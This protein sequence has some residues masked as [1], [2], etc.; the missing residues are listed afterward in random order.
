ME[1]TVKLALIGKEMTLSFGVT[2]PTF[3]TAQIGQFTV[4]V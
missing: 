3:Q 1:L 2:M 4:Q